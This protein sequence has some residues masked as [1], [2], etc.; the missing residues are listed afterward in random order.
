VFIFGVFAII[1]GLVISLILQDPRPFPRTITTVFIALG[2]ACLASGIA[3]F[4]EIESKWVRAGGPLGV[5]VFLCFFISQ[6]S[7][8]T[9]FRQTLSDRQRGLDRPLGNDNSPGMSEKTK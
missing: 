3:G 8:S 7:D 9:G 2:G 4:L 6:S 1:A 5:L